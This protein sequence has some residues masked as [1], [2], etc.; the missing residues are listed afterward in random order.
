VF[1]THGGNAKKRHYDI[2][3]YADELLFSGCSFYTL[4]SEE[5]APAF[6]PALP[7]EKIMK[8]VMWAVVIL[9]SIVMLAVI[10][11]LLA[12][13]PPPAPPAD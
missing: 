6:S 3:K 7:R 10:V 1:Q 11:K 12:F 2:E 4:G 8:G 13:S 9:A 5:P